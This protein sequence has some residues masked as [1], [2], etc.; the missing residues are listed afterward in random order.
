[1]NKKPE[2]PLHVKLQ[3]KC[4]EKCQH[5]ISNPDKQI[6]LRIVECI[7]EISKNLAI[8]YENDFLPMVHKIWSPMIQRFHYDDPVVKIRIIYLLFDF[9]VLC[10]EFLNRRFLNEFLKP[11]MCPFMYEQSKLSMNHDSTYVYTQVYKLQTSILTNI[12]KMCILYEIKD[13]DLE[14]LIEMVIL[15]HLDKR[16]PKK[17]QNL[18]LEALKNVSHIDS[19]IVWLVLHYILPFDEADKKDLAHSKFIKKKNT[20]NIY[21][22]DEILE[23]LFDIFK[24]I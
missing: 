13:M 1:M 2:S 4:L 6:R 15:N 10:G 12:D 14:F 24:S 8:D 3:T 11:K 7:R 5:L 16:Q 22:S 21:L 17:L 20:T 9:S 19:D 23:S 18:A